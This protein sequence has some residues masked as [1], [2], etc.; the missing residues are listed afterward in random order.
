MPRFQHVVIAAT[1]NPASVSSSLLNQHIDRIANVF[2]CES[3][4]E[5]YLQRLHVSRSF[6]QTR[7]KN[8]RMYCVRHELPAWFT[9]YKA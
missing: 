3:C 4:Y 9:W 6:K 8:S 7:N 5:S 1:A 2:R